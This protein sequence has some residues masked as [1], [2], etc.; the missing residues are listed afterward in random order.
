MWSRFHNFTEYILS[1]T[2]II[3][4]CTDLA[5]NS[6]PISE[7]LLYRRFHGSDYT[8]CSFLVVTSYSL[9]A[10]YQ[11]WRGSGFPWNLSVYLYDYI[12]SDLAVL[13]K[14]FKKQS[15]YFK[16][17]G[18]DIQT[19]QCSYK[20]GYVWSLKKQSWLLY[21]WTHWWPYMVQ[22]SFLQIWQN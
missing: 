6:L 15:T 5:K 21:T 17:K 22:Y 11:H 16:T 18:K 3:L 12:R 4:T 20:Q 2:L 7:V 10:R 8:Y 13:T 14:L 19:A 9:V 1:S